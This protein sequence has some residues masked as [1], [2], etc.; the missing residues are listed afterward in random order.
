MIG[1]GKNLGRGRI[2]KDDDSGRATGRNEA[3]E[4]TD[5]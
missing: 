4:S 1:N 3:S 5:A 2:S